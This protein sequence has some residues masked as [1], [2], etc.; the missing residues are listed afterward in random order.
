M[1]VEHMNRKKTGRGVWAGE[2]KLNE[3]EK[4]LEEKMRPGMEGYGDS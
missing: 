2:S 1:S 3:W 4:K